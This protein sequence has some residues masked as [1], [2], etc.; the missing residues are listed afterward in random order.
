MV[1]ERL[2]FII[3]ILVFPKITNY[4]GTVSTQWVLR[5]IYSL[6]LRGTM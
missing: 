2:L 6:K 3:N 4:F 1:G 5:E